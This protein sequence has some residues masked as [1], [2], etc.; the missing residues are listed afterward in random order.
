M[1]FDKHVKLSKM[2]HFDNGLYILILQ[3]FIKVELQHQINAVV[4]MNYYCL[5]FEN[6]NTIKLPLNISKGE[7]NDDNSHPI[8]YSFTI[9]ITPIK[10][11][12]L[13][14]RWRKACHL[15]LLRGKFDMLTSIQPLIHKLHVSIRGKLQ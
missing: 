9:S 8:D 14:T 1:I 2:A 5:F 11:D 7:E 13:R 4:S 10:I 3:L 12:I 15:A 6:I